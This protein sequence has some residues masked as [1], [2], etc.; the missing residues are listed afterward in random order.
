MVISIILFII[1]VYIIYYILYIIYYILYII[2]YIL[3]IFS[4]PICFF[5]FLL[6]VVRFYSSLLQDTCIYIYI[7]RFYNFIKSNTWSPYI[8]KYISTHNT[9]EYSGSGN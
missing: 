2:Y 4:Y 9:L 6:F 3:Y 1:I 5:V 7:Y 8:H